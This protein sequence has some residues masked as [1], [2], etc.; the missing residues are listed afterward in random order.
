MIPATI[1]VLE[2]FP[3][4]ASG[5]VDRLNLPKPVGVVGD[6]VAPRTLTEEIVA[7]VMA[8]ILG[9]KEVGVN[10]DFFD[11]GGHS[12]LIPRVTS[13]LNDLFA[14]ELQIGRASCRERG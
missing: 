12:L 11:L 13:R 9:L 1:V 4:T 5:K 10:D 6:Y 2:D 7:E 3:R 8:E 14:V